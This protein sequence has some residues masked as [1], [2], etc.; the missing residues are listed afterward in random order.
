MVGVEKEERLATPLKR[1]LKLRHPWL[2]INLLTAFLAAIDAKL[3]DEYVLYSSHQDHDGVPAPSARL[4]ATEQAASLMRM[5]DSLPEREREN[6]WSEFREVP[7]T[8]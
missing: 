8:W 7:R 2:Q 6:C 5:V 4:E 3:R 1:S